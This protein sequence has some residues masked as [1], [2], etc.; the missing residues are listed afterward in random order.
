MDPQST[1]PDVPLQAAESWL[2][3]RQVSPAEIVERFLVHLPLYT[4]KYTYKGSLYTAVVEG[5]TGEVFANIYPAKADAPYLLA[6]GVPPW[7]SCAWLYSHWSGGDRAW[8]RGEW[9]IAMCGP[10]PGGCAPIV[11]FGRVGGGQDMT[12]KEALHV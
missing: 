7:F 9:F 11:C 10:R 2:A 3:Q 4:F 8:R 12:E 5:G 6:G 1:T